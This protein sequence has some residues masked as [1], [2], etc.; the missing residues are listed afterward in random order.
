MD[1]LRG[2]SLASST[3]VLASTTGAIR[4]AKTSA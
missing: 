1:T 3:T 2:R 4:R